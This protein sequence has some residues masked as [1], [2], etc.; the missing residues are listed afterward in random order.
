MRLK[1]I[2]KQI[3]RLDYELVKLLNQRLELILRAT[4][5]GDKT[6]NEEEENEYRENLEQ[7]PEGI[8]DQQFISGLFNN[9]M[10]QCQRVRLM[11]Q[12]LAAFQGEH[13]ANSEVA[14]RAFDSKMVPVP[15]VKFVDVFDG[16]K[17]GYFDYGMVPVENSL[18]GGVVEVNDLLAKYDLYIVGE[19]RLHIKHTLMTLAD[20]DPRGIK[21]VYSH[22]QALAQCRQYISHHDFEVRPFYNTAGAAREISIARPKASAAIANKLCARIYDLKIVAENIQDE[23]S[24]F[25][26][27]VMLAKKQQNQPG[28]KCS[29]VFSTQHECGA[30][31]KVLT[32]FARARVN[33]TR[34]ES[35]PS[36]VEPGNFLFL[37]DFNGSTAD[38]KITETLAAVKRISTMYKFLGCYNEAKQPAKV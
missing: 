22:P 3:K 38:K 13:G 27:F 1:E 2:R 14:V 12:K 4:R 21:V 30:L 8:A 29:I 33:L 26:R 11:K 35:R 5:F 19:T 32:I 24:N 10:E 25:T 20:T 23:N 7:I 17:Q 18:E 31:N 28:D 36:R 37:V 9:I 6:V 15:C 16:V 34:I